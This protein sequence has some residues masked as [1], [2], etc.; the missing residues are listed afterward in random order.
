MKVILLES[1]PKVGSVN[2]IVDVS[3]GFAM[4]SL[5]PK[6]LAKVASPK[7]IAEAEKQ[8]KENKARDDAHKKEISEA[9]KSLNGETLTMVASA[10]EKGTLFS[11]ISA[12]DIAEAIQ[13]QKKLEI[14]P[15]YIDLDQAIKEIGPRKVA[16]TLEDTTATLT[17]EITPEA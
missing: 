17:V 1:V 11:A 8:L 14:D 9:I 10:N 15:V 13:E 2:E 12:G 16:I 4:N 5:I 6:G 7:N 3:D